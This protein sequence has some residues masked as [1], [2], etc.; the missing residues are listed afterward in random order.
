MKNQFF[1][2]I[3]NIFSKK[4]SELGKIENV[5]WQ[6]TAGLNTEFELQYIKDYLL[7]DIEYNAVF[8]YS[9]YLTIL[10][11]S[12][13]VFSNDSPQIPNEFRQYLKKY[14]NLGY[15]Y[16]LLH[17]SNEKR[18][19]KHNFNYYK[20]ANHVFRAYYDPRILLKNLTTI[21]IGFK[22]GFLNTEN[23]LP[24][25]FERT[26]VWTFI[27]QLKSD[28][29]QMYNALVSITPQY[30]T[31]T[32]QWNAP[33]HSV[34][35]IIEV[36][37][38][39]IFIPCPM[40]SSNPD[41][42]RINEALEWGCIPIVKKFNNEDYFKYVY[43]KHPFII[44]DSWPEANAIIKNMLTDMPKLEA[45]R[46]QIWAWYKNYKQTLQSRIKTILLAG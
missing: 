30:T 18:A 13:I 15:N 28:R 27:G 24:S 8:D 31:V 43:G 10:N 34:N 25:V 11:N 20:N 36:Y 1:K 33:E 9:K 44:V 23:C 26:Y 38:K 7:K 22:S 41:S 16:W 2:A 6:T 32:N 19:H 39:T 35:Q 3:K 14:D 21:P 17:L 42:F 5:I 40:G 45:F 4:L 12:L 46:Q 29:Q 37:K